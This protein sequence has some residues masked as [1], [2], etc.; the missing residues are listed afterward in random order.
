[1]GDSCVAKA[2]ASSV[3]LPGRKQS[4]AGAIADACLWA[5][6]SA[7]FADVIVV[8]RAACA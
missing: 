6:A 8:Q 2:V 5:I 1:M 3:A 4:S 7:G